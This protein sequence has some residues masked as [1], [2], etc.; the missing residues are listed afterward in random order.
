V[1]LKELRA[2]EQRENGYT[3]FAV[4]ATFEHMPL[5]HDDELDQDYS[6]WLTRVL[7]AGYRKKVGSTLEEIIDPKTGS[8]PST[9]VLLDGEGGVLAVAAAP[10]YRTFIFHRE[11]EFAPLNLGN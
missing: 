7:D 6:P 4:S 1:K 2:S 10:K 3:F 5:R 11:K 8:K 9:P